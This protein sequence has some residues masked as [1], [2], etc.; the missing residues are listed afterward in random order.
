MGMKRLACIAL[1]VSGCATV[2][3]NAPTRT[4][5]HYTGYP[6]DLHDEGNRISGSV[7]GV[8]VDY[9]IEQ[10][11]GATVLT[12]FSG[13]RQP[14]YLEVR[15][16][17]GKRHIVGTLS[18]RAAVGEVDLTL[19]P[20]ELK[21]RSGLRNFRLIATA[22]DTFDGTMTALDQQGQGDATV[23]GRAQLEA[24]PPAEAGTILPTLLNCEGKLSRFLNQNPLYVRI[25][26]PPGY[27]P[28]TANALR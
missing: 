6:Y 17:D 15:D 13:T 12:G 19:S 14:V 11:N 27:E 10:R 2:G 23:E 7:C 22:D 3:S 18:S 26:G 5:Q 21:G 16:S 28:R 20:T 8:N 1:L 4:A 9:T 25:G 24:L